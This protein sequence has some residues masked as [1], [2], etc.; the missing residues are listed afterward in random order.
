[1]E[2]E[3]AIIPQLVES[4][5]Q[6]ASATES[7]VAGSDNSSSVYTIHCQKDILDE[8]TRK[9]LFTDTFC[10][11]C[12][13]MLQFESQRIS[14]YEGKKHAQKVRLY[15][16]MH[17]EQEEA[18]IKKPKIDHVNFHVDGSSVVDKNK[19]CSLCNMVFTSAIVAQ[20][21]YVGKV[22]AKKLRQ[23]TGDQV[24]LSPLSSQFFPQTTQLENDTLVTN[25]LP[26]IP[27]QT[28]AEEPK[29]QDAD[30]ELLSSL[31]NA[32]D[33]DDPDKYC[34]L[35]SAPFN[36]PLM[37]QQHYIGKKHQRNMARKKMMAEMQD[38]AVSADSNAGVGTYICPICNITLTSIE[39]YQSHM[40]GNKH[41]IK[42]NM[43]VNLMKNSKKT[44][45]SFQDELADYIKVQQARGLE[46]K[47]CFRK[48]GGGERQESYEHE[49]EKNGNTEWSKDFTFKQGGFPESS[50]ISHTVESRLPDW[51]PV[52]D[53][54]LRKH[55]PQKFVCSAEQSRQMPS[56]QSS[57][58][59]HP[60][61]VSHKDLKQSPS[62][63]EDSSSSSNS[64]SNSYKKARRQKR[65]HREERRHRRDREEETAKKKRKKS[66]EETDSGRDDEKLKSKKEKLEATEPTNGEKSKHRKEKKNKQ[67]TPADKGD[68]KHKKEKKTKTKDPRTEEEKLWDESIL[69]F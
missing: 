51:S 68:K 67:E 1:M 65:K 11:V 63:K 61:V 22:H 52:Q 5:N 50:S 3:G 4:L 55:N 9:K 12:G 56:F 15:F 19:F 37:A 66:S 6:K 14:H 10:K 36:S 64:S 16:Q 43:V 40:Q 53:S 38:E 17:Q 35:C 26:A 20:S 41:Q 42:E 49:K 57:L 33:L 28:P 32:L 24:L 34:K 2:S 45:S 21:H 13:A 47:T 69:G 44:Y 18:I 58:C 29:Q 48:P 62:D 54:S 30:T 7:S 46:P 39:M 23:L 60:S 59:N 27:P 31:D 25:T 8:Q